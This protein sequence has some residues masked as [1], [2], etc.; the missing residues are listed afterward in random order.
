MSILFNSNV[1]KF[2]NG[3]ENKGIDFTAWNYD[4]VDNSK[5]K[6]MLQALPCYKNNKCTWYSDTV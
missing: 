1:L 5:N 6:W 3:F 2:E 4:A